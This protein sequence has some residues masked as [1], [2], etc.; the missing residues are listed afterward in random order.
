M[1]NRDS[2]TLFHIFAGTP[3]CSRRDMLQNGCL[4]RLALGLFR[5]L[6]R[7][8]GG[9]SSWLDGI[10]RSV[11]RRQLRLSLLGN[12]CG[13]DTRWHGCIGSRGSPGRGCHCSLRRCLRE[14]ECHVTRHRPILFHRQ[15]HRCLLA[16]RG[17][18][19][20]P[21]CLTSRF[22]CLSQLRRRS[23]FECLLGEAMRPVEANCAVRYSLSIQHR[24]ATRM[25][26][27]YVWLG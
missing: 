5:T 12:A 27:R 15:V 3:V 26:R 21:P 24:E 23:R 2:T 4:L 9:R 14:L 22:T 20:E 8:F 11:E 18:R 17:S 25:T 7:L 19:N 13:S 16:C 1:E 6:I 10:Q